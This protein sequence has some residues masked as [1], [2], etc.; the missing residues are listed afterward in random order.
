LQNFGL[1]VT[2]KEE[3]LERLATSKVDLHR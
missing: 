2:V 3:V 1:S